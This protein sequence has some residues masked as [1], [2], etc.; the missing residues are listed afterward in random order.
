[1]ISDVGKGKVADVLI[2]KVSYH[3]LENFNKICCTYSYSDSQ[4]IQALLLFLIIIG[5]NTAVSNTWFLMS[6]RSTKSE[7]KLRI[8]V[9]NFKKK[10]L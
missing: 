7:Q 5:N 8:H 2:M 3:I 9:R 1:M 4:N 10:F 6:S